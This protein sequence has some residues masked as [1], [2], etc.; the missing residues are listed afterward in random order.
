MYVTLYLRKLKMPESESSS[1]ANGFTCNCKVGTLIEKYEMGEMNRELADEWGGKQ[2][3]S[4]S[5]RV[6]TERFN[7]RILRTEMTATGMDLIEGRVKNFYRLLTDEEV[8]DAMALQA[9]TTL[10]EKGV[11][12]DILTNRFV[13]HQTMYRHL[14]DCL[15]VEKETKTVAVDSER[16]RLNQLQNRSE[17]V[18]KD[19]FS[20]LQRADEISL[21]DFEVLVNFRVSCE[22]CGTLYDAAD[23]LD[24]E[25]CTCQ[26]S[27]SGIN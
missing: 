23:L 19:S 22:D 12:I 5:I 13:S 8:L 9:R 4:P 21:D 24:Q 25:G 1:I 2:D 18:I 14:R 7:R 10:E 11:E 27:S 3:N 17:A 15:E 16:N 20:R 6:L 26:D